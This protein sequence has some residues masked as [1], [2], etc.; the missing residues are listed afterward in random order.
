MDAPGGGPLDAVERSLGHRF[1]DRRLLVRSLTHA[2]FANEDP[3]AEDNETLE[4]L[5]DA[6]LDLLVGDLLVR[7]FP[8]EGEGTLSKA[9]ALLVSEGHFAA[10]ARRLGLG[11]AL[12]VPPAEEHAKLRERD[13]ALSDALEAVFAAVYLDGGFQAA[14]EAARRLFADDV[15]ALDPS[16]LTRR[17]PKTA[18]Q[19]SAQAA[20]LGLPLYRLLEESG[21]PHARRFVYEVTYGEDRRA[22][23]EGSSKKEAQR[24][25]AEQLLRLL[26]EA[27]PR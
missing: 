2:S 12:R 7:G 18:L 23:G 10:L 14:R 11:A 22:R 19:E 4:F 21:Q 15:A 17:D 5:G 26:G 16:T 24:D 9:R 1:R 13:S 6:L 20:G 3:H 8:L 27:G 25:A